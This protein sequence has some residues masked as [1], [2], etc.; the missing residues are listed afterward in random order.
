MASGLNTR[1]MGALLPVHDHDVARVQAIVAAGD[2]QELAL[3]YSIPRTWTARSFRSSSFRQ[4]LVMA[5]DPSCKRT[6]E[7]PYPWP[8]RSISSSV[9]GAPKIVA[10]GQPLPAPRVVNPA[11]QPAPA[12]EPDEQ[13]TSPAKIASTLSA[14]RPQVPLHERLGERAD[15]GHHACVAENHED[16]L[17]MRRRTGWRNH[18]LGF[19]GR[20]AAVG[21]RAERLKV[22]ALAID[23][24]ELEPQGPDAYHEVRHEDDDQQQERRP[25]DQAL[26]FRACVSVPSK[27][28]SRS[29]VSPR[30]SGPG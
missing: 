27:S 24:G 28:R 25:R 3:P 9:E 20:V 18:L 23:P 13:H 21:E 1:S 26:H 12:R 14:V 10:G 17:M 30:L 11:R 5:G 7:T 2:G 16:Q 19:A 22:G 15:R 6:R 4:Q 8:T 29:C